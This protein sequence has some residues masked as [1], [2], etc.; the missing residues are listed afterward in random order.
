MMAKERMKT[1]SRFKGVPE[2]DDDTEDE[3][4]SLPDDEEED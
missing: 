3:E 2:V 1:S 4:T